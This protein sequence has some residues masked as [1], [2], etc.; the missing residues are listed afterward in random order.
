MLMG[1]EGRQWVEINAGEIKTPEMDIV[2]GAGDPGI[3]A[4]AP[5]E[6]QQAKPLVRKCLWPWC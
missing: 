6:S 2:W 4:Q 1:V 5:A 3:G